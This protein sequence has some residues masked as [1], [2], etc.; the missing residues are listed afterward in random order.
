M[1]RI[2]K[3]YIFMLQTFLPQFLMTFLICLFIVMMQ[4]LWRYIDELVGKGLSIDVVAELFFYAAL[5]LVPLALPLAILLASLMTFGNLGEHVELTAMKSSGISLV[6][7]MA[8]LMV[9]MAGV[10]VGAFFFQNNVTP[11]SQVKMWTLLFSM[12]QKTPTLDIPEGT[13]FTQIPG[14]NLYV[15]HKDK[16]TD[17]LYNLLIYDV[18]AG[19]GNPRI[20]AADSGRMSFTEDYRHLVLNLYQGNWY[21][22]MRGSNGGTVKMGQNLYRRESFHDKEIMIPYDN[23]FT[24]M[25]DET[26]KSQYVGKNIQQL[27]HTIDS[28][29]LRVDSVGKEM[30]RDM[31][32][33]P[34][35][36]VPTRHVVVRDGG[37]QYEMV[38]P[39]KLSRPIDFD[40]LVTN[41]SLAEQL[42][43]IDQATMITQNMRQDF[44]F[45]GYSLNDDNFVIRRHKI[46]MHKKF[47]L[48]LACLIFFFIGA[49]LGAIIRKGGLG[50]PIVISVILFIFYYII[51]NSGYKLARDGRWP[52]W[53]G[54]WL[55]S[56][57]L[58]PLGIFLTKKAV[59]DSAVFNPDAYRNFFRRIVGLHQV[60]SLAIKEVV[61]NEVDNTLA[62]SQ[63]EELKQLCA[64]FLAKYPGRQSYLQYWQYGYD[65]ALLRQVAQATDTLVDHLSN[66]RDQMVINKAM[67]FPVIRQ[68]LT[69]HPTNYPRL[70]LGLAVLLPI[71]LPGYL[72]GLRHQHNLKRDIAQTITVCDQLAAIM[73][74]EYTRDMEYNV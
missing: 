26:M 44:I 11:K 30:T 2:K 20:V 12:R 43:M 48:S 45:R 8:P 72:V 42:Q 64:N 59:N 47:T 6:K 35:L 37:S 38:K 60:R 66:S 10:A 19:T 13:V 9:L 50:T 23:T 1:F 34:V 57:V 15:K 68:L 7:V 25:D 33:R 73:R 55:S 62:L 14:Y 53:Q 16:E 70:G 46:E 40:S 29:Q 4:F 18:S 51:D 69:Y 41:L 52:V 63:I 5:S 65:K 31:R 28:V 3:L 39:V 36:G 58:L 24:R 17:M 54:I 74:G 22:D 56:A 71:G 49:P 21:E 32:A 61:I 67:D 27:Q